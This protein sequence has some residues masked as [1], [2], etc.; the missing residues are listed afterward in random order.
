MKHDILAGA[1]S[2]AH[3]NYLALLVVTLEVVAA[4]LLA[5]A[6]ELPPM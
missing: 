6:I 3:I 2:T 4:A 1:F 5:T